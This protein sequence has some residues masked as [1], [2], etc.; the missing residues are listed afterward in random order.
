MNDTLTLIDNNP[1]VDEEIAIH[2]KET[3]VC[4]ALIP[5]I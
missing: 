4:L 2:V 3:V 5:F 1:R